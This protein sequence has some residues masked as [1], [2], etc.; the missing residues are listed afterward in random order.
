MSNLS[1]KW[2]STWCC[3]KSNFKQTFNI[4]SD[5]WSLQRELW[6]SRVGNTHEE[7][8]NTMCSWM[9]TEHCTERTRTT[10]KDLSKE[11]HWMSEMWSESCKRRSEQRRTFGRMSR[12]M[13]KWMFSSSCTKQTK[14]TQQDMHTHSSFMSEVQRTS[15]KSRTWKQTS[16]KMSNSMWT[17]LWCNCC[18]NESNGSQS[19]PMPKND[20]WMLSS[21]C[22]MSMERTKI[23]FG[24]SCFRM[25]FL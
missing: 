6:E 7:L 12:C 9:W 24:S 8:S 25:S 19:T 10:W 2:R 5:L 15:C 1:W 17:R 11:D 3:D 23:N 21:W 4:E 16:P 14:W 18:T 22:S 13:S 20:C